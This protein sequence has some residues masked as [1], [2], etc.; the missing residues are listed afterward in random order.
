MGNAVVFAKAFKECGIGGKFSKFHIA[1]SNEWFEL[2]NIDSLEDSRYCFKVYDKLD[3]RLY[4]QVTGGDAGLLHK[5]DPQWATHFQ[6]AQKVIAKI[7]SRDN[8][9]GET[10]YYIDYLHQSV[11]L[12]NR[13][14]VIEVTPVL[15][16]AP[17]VSSYAAYDFLSVY[18]KQPVTLDCDVRVFCRFGKVVVMCNNRQLNSLVT[19]EEF[20]EQYGE[21]V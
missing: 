8:N 7:V 12:I 17:T 13:M 3:H 9:R 20:N 5:N 19:P 1:Q 6:T 18:Q 2:I 21:A 16:S 4:T 10:R 15:R 11:F 14:F